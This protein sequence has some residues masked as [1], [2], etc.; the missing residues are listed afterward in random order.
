VRL[1]KR[2]LYGVRRG[3]RS[4]IGRDTVV[5]RGDV[6]ETRAGARAALTLCDGSRLYLNASTTVEIR[7]RKASDVRSGEVS[8]RAHSGATQR[9][10]SSVAQGTTRGGTV[11]VRVAR[12]SATYTVAR[13]SMIV[14]NRR[15]EVRVAA[16]QQT[17]VQRDQAPR[18]PS[19]VDAARTISW[20]A[21]LLTAAWSVVAR[22]DPSYS[23]IGV[24][25]N[26]QGDVYA[27]DLPTAFQSVVELS[28]GGKE[29]RSWGLQAKDGE[30]NGLALDHQGNVY[31][32]DSTNARIEKF[33]PDGRYL[34]TLGSFDAGAN[35]VLADMAI[36]PSGNIFIAESNNAQ[37]DKLSPSGQT[38][39]TVG[40]TGTV[41]GRLSGPTDIALD[42][43]GDFY[44]VENTNGRVQKFSPA[45][46]SLQ[47]IG[48]GQFD[49]PR[50]VALDAVGDIYVTDPPEERIDE[51]SPAG[52]LIKVWDP[53]GS[54]VGGFD[55]PYD[56]AFN[57]AGDMFV[58]D[59]HNHRI[60]KLVR[61]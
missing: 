51:F 6:L 5:R 42:K 56:L 10:E 22:F 47:T 26:A 3:R 4:T 39:L 7:Q 44:V 1:V 30:I 33:T 43:A 12:N 40:G 32:T 21:P 19:R 59:F 16:N 35:L 49:L 57:S 8:V 37:V 27:A 14:Q 18:R 61:Q 34:T 31:V 23:P 29:L 2:A 54:A 13:G 24:D 52:R 53:S 25:V 45:G 11:D 46:K 17:V 55:G 50:S 9:L 58:T 41:P 38:L 36:D 20:T 15:G 28:P 48:S 60:L